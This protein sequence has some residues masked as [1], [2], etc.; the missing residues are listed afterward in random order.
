MYSMAEISPNKYHSRK[1]IN[2]SRYTSVHT[3]RC[4]ERRSCSLGID[5]K[6]CSIPDKNIPPFNFIFQIPENPEYLSIC[7]LRHPMDTSKNQTF[8]PQFDDRRVPHDRILWSIH[9]G[10]IPL[11]LHHLKLHCLYHRAVTTISSDYSI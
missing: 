8:L 10:R 6:H 4:R 3:T 7:Y 9:H 5:P 11:F 2:F 1:R